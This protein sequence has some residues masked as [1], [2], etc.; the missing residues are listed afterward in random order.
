MQINYLCDEC[1]TKLGWRWP[2]CHCATDH[3][4]ACDVCG[5]SEMLSYENDWLK[6]GETELREWD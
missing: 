4:G 5:M 2:E 3:V 1:A 6:D